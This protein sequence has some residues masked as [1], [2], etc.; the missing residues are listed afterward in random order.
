MDGNFHINY[1]SK[2]DCYLNQRVVMIKEKTLPNIFIRYQIEPYI[3]LREKSVSR[4]T[5]GHLSDK[6]LK[7]INILVPTYDILENMKPLFDNF[8]KKTISNQNE[9]QKL[10]SLC[11]WLLPILMNGQVKVE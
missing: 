3:Q 8:L 5:V 2:N 1:W 7:G 10:S 4:T 6:D 9:N 11:D